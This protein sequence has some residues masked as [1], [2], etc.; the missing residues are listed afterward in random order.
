MIRNRLFILF[1]VPV[2]LLG[3][4][5]FIGAQSWTPSSGMPPANNTAAPVN[6][7]TTTQAKNGNLAAN[8]FAA[9]TEMRS[10]RYCDALGGNCFTATSSSGGSS[11][12]SALTAGTGITFTPSTI[13]SSGTISAN[14]A[15]VQQRV[16]GSCPVGQ[17]IRQINADGTVVCQAAPATCVWKAQ[18]Y[19]QGARCR[20]GSL[21]C[22]VSG[23]S[24]YL[25]QECQPDGTWSSQNT[26]CS[27]SNGSLAACP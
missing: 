21:S 14:T 1:I 24:G 19:S 12:I 27:L 22:T 23:S 9:T 11:G 13:T 5:S 17:G 20:T 16:S 7:G 2:C 18:N 6:I 3:G 15:V 4:Y 10:N 8:I 25:Y 26:G